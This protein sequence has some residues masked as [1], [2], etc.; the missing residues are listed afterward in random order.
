VSFVLLLA[1]CR[2]FGLTWSILGD[3]RQVPG[4]W[5]HLGRQALA[6]AFGGLGDKRKRALRIPSFLNQNGCSVFKIR[7]R[8]CSDLFGGTGGRG[9]VRLSSRKENRQVLANRDDAQDQRK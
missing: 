6:G 8:A 5:G 7:G 3:R 9:L 1:A 2:A 4:W